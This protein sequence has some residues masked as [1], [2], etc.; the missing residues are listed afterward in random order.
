MKQNSPIIKNSRKYR[1]KGYKLISETTRFFRFESI[2][3]KPVLF[4]AGQFINFYIES[5]EETFIRSF[6]IANPPKKKDFLDIVCSYIKGGLASEYLFNLKIED[7]IVASEPMGNFT[8]PETHEF[9]ERYIFICTGTAIVPYRSMLREISFLLAKNSKLQIILILGIRY[10]SDFLFKDDFLNFAK[11]HPQFEIRL[12]CSNH[13]DNYSLSENSISKRYI[14]E[15]LKDLE[16]HM[17]KDL[18]YLCGNPSMINDVINILTTLGFD[19]QK[20]KLESNSNPILNADTKLT[21][22]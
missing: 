15:H 10:Q 5:N 18:I 21:T 8:L 13:K 17:N 9:Y 4:R 19:H 6:S 20:I 2:D 16:F 3:K 1:L 22:G 11:H 7:T 12:A 14:Q